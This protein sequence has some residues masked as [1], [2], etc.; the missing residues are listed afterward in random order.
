[1][2]F[3]KRDSTG[4]PLEVIIPEDAT[5]GMLFAQYI[6]KVAPHPNAAKLA[7]D[8]FYSDEG[9]IMFAQGYAHPGRSDVILPP[10][11]AGKLLPQSAYPKLYFPS[12]LDNFSK[13]IKAVKDGW[14]AI[15]GGS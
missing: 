1:M 10:D 5:V 2:G 14:E 15:V 11:V 9:Q 6:N 13:A 8:F 12:N 3:N 4:L 7:I